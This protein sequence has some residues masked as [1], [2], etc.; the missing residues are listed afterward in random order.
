M[1]A[2]LPVR[3]RVLIGAVENSVA[4]NAYRPWDVLQ[5]RKGIT[6]ENANTDAEGRLVMGDCLAEACTEKPDVLLDFATLTGA[7]RV[8]VG[9]AIAAV[10]AN[11]DKLYSDLEKHAD[12]TVD[13]VWRL[14]LHKPYRALIESQVADVSSASDGPFG[15]AIT[16]AL[17]LQEF[18]DDDVPWAHFDIMAWNVG[19]KPGRPTGG[20]AMG[21]RAAYGMIADRFGGN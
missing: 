11:D 5:T 14:P 3:L 8:A 2:K 9:T 19:S 13:P 16:A 15:G 6:V 20:E 1:A 17:F 10:F 21:L 4:G 12:A 18:V 7:A